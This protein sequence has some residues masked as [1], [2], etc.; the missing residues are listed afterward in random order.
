MIKIIWM[1]RVRKEDHTRFIEIVI[2][3]HKYSVYGTSPRMTSEEARDILIKQG[4]EMPG[5]GTYMTLGDHQ[6]TFGSQN[7]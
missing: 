6:V 3:D 1:D 5:N 4:R 2:F 7:N